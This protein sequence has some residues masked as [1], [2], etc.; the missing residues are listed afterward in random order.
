MKIKKGPLYLGLSLVAL[1]LTGRFLFAPHAQ[2]ESSVKQ[3]SQRQDMGEHLK[4]NQTT[5]ES[6][7]SFKSFRE[8]NKSSADDFKK[9][10]KNAFESIPNLKD[11]QSVGIILGDIKMAMNDRS[12]LFNHGISFYR[13]CAKS[14]S[15]SDSVRSLCLASLMEYGELKDGPQLH[16]K[17]PRS[18]IELALRAVSWP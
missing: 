5:D 6:F 14:T 18:V 11:I 7:A 9:L 3:V 12:D 17:Y 13:K 2:V 16:E 15:L 1:G 10:L 8:D 4:K